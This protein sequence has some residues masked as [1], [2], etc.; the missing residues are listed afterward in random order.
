MIKKIIKCWFYKPSLKYPVH[1][2]TLENEPRWQSCPSPGK[3]RSWLPA[4]LPLI[5]LNPL[6]KAR[7]SPLNPDLLLLT[8]LGFETPSRFSQE[9]R[10]AP[11]RGHL[12][13]PGSIL[14][15][16]LPK[17]SCWHSPLR[18][19]L[20]PC[21]RTKEQPLPIKGGNNLIKTKLAAPRDPVC[22]Q[23]AFPAFPLWFLIIYARYLI[24]GY[25][26]IKLPASITS[27]KLVKINFN[28]WPWWKPN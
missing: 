18:P 7:S 17:L 10:A 13:V 1:W 24:T 15:A 4:I 2:G 28:F 9:S 12:G 11:S 20:L 8:L 23:E 5:T 22:H 21:P 27:R 16:A 19:C 3:Q 6:I 14:Q 25:P 26:G